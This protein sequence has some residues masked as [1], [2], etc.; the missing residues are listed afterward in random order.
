MK[1]IESTLD[2]YRE[3]TAWMAVIPALTVFLATFLSMRITLVSRELGA[4]LSVLFMVIALFLFIMSD[5]Y[6]RRIVF[7]E[8]LNE[9]ELGALYRKAAYYSGLMIPLVGFISAILVGYPDAP[10]TALSFMI[11]S[12]SGLGSAWKRFSDKMTG[13]L[14][15][16]KGG[17]DESF[18]EKKRKKKGKD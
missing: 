10:F 15:L 6:V 18:K 9:S 12:L 1:P 4:M 8:N 3:F 5:R 11:I 16:P 2:S 17:S 7:S 14:V 13:K